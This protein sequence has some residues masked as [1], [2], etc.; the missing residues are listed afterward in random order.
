M[1]TVENDCA[2]VYGSS[3]DFIL[4][5]LSMDWDDKNTAQTEIQKIA[6]T[7]YEYLN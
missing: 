2:V 3:T 1:D 6:G 4:V 7:V 5:V